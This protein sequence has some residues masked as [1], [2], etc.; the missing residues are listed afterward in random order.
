MKSALDGRISIQ[1]RFLFR[2]EP[3]RLSTQ[4][5]WA[6]LAGKW[7]DNTILA[8]HP[9]HQGATDECSVW[10]GRRNRAGVTVEARIKEL[11]C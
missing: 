7:F 6:F 4:S 9:S 3:L 10:Q 11:Q 2:E 8:L 5:Q 1:Q